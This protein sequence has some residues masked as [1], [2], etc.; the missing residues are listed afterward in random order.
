[1]LPIFYVLAGLGAAFLV[2]FLF[3]YQQDRQN[4]RDDT[5][6][7]ARPIILL[8]LATIMWISTMPAYTAVN[9]ST[10]ALPS[11]TITSNS[12]TGNTLYTIQASNIIT[13]TNPVTGGI[14]N[15]YLYLWLAIMST[16]FI[17]WFMFFLTWMNDIAEGD[18]VSK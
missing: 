15:G 5:G 4:F 9:Q 11:Y 3:S 10:I 13:T 8:M 7:M 6:S 12:S 1:M 16:I 17:L 14:L 18:M 2:L